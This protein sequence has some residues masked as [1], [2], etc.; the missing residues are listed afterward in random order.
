MRFV[1]VSIFLF[2]QLLFAQE[3]QQQQQAP[4]TDADVPQVRS[5]KENKGLEVGVDIDQQDPNMDALYKKGPYLVYD[6]KNKHWV[7]TQELEYKRCQIQRK[8]SLLD[9]EN[10]LA[11][12]YFD[13]FDRREDCWKKQQELTN[14]AKYE[15][16]CLHPTKV[17]NRLTF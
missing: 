8:T 12:A 14:V 10:E 3:Q 5:V 13:V 11:C 15:Q 7:C 1:F 6:C 2:S 4:V 17:E 9:Y 16:F